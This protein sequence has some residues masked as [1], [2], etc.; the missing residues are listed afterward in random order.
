M[1]DSR[2]VGTVHYDVLRSDA[3]YVSHHLCYSGHMAGAYLR[4]IHVDL[5][6]S[7][8]CNLHSRHLPCAIVVRFLFL[9][10]EVVSEI[11]S[12][13]LYA[14]ADPYSD[15][16]S[17]LSQLLLLLQSVP[18]IEQLQCLFEGGGIIAAFVYLTRSSGIW[19]LVRGDE[20]DLSDLKAIDS[21]FLCNKIHH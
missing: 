19:H 20:V 2:I 14:A 17:F 8:L 16:P 6:P 15:K 7:I 1:T 9:G 13:W 10:K 4:S 12:S 5:N 3:E 21:Q 11:G 18:I